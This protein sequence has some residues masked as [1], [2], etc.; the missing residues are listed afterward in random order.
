M[1]IVTCFHCQF[2]ISDT[3]Y[4]DCLDQQYLVARLFSSLKIMVQ[5]S[6]IIFYQLLSLIFNKLGITLTQPKHIYFIVL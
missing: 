2:F 5:C 4:L 3:V 6:C 1:T